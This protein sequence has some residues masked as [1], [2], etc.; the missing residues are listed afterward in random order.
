MSQQPTITDVSGI[1]QFACS[2]VAVVIF[3]VNE[4]EKFLMLSS[5]PKRNEEDGWETIS[6]ALEAGETILEGALRE[7]REEIGPHVRVRPLGIVH[8]YSFHYDENVKFMISICCLMA[9]EGGK[10]Q[11]GDD[12]EGSRYRWWSLEE[13]EDENVPIV[14]P[15]NRK[16]LLR[17]TIELY[18]LWGDSPTD[19]QHLGLK[20]MG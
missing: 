13:L 1:R 7:V 18:R 19:L 2:A 10:V 20:P 3:I 9:Y 4:E 8:A 14:V 17:R 16:W 5:P 15:T 6:G 12:M 11:P